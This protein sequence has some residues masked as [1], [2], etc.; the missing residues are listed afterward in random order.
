MG[1]SISANKSKGASPEIN[2]TPLVDVVLVLLIIFMVV[3]PAINEGAQIEL[4]KVEAPDAKQRDM[5]PIEVTVAP[6]GTTVVE[7]QT[8]AAKDLK[9]TL[10]AMHEKEPNRSLMLKSDQSMKWGKMRSAFADL[11]GIGFK[12]VLLK[13]VAKKTPGQPDGV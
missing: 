3:T 5:H 7:K 6:D 12:G 1:A 8:I 4:P 13:V 11:Q 9:R 10:T 2:I